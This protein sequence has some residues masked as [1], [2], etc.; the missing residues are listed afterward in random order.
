VTIVPAMPEVTICVVLTGSPL[1]PETPIKIDD[2]VS[3]EA[4]CA[5]VKWI[6]PSR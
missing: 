3:A 5:G 6:L 2:T 4:P 1:K